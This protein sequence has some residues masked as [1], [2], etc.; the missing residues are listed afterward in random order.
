[1]GTD[2][3]AVDKGHQMQGMINMIVIIVEDD[4]KC[5]IMDGWVYKQGLTVLGFVALQSTLSRD[6]YYFSIANDFAY[7]FLLN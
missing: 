7:Q 3:E 4:Q 6:V 2:A 1:M 5:V